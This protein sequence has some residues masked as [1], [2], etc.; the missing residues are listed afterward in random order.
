MFV[1]KP[2]N[3]DRKRG[4]VYIIWDIKFRSWA[5]VEGISE[6]LTPSFDSKLPS[7]ESD[8][9]DNMDPT[10]KTKGIA[11]KQNAG[12][13]DAMVQSISDT[14]NFHCILQNMNKDADWPHGNAWKT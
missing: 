2:L 7:K 3:F 14:D 12:A 9:L 5:G 4:S 1:S 11:Q 10:Q 13:M 8:I 6:A